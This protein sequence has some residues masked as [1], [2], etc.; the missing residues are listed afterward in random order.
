[1]A[2]AKRKPQAAK[3]VAPARKGKAS[4]ERADKIRRI[5]RKA[6]AKRAQTKALAK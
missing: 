6:A 2:Q 1:M 4:K 5:F 3:T